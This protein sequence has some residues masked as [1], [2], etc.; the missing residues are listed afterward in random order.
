V[1]DEAT[2]ALDNET[3]KLVNK[4]IES[5]AGLKTLIVI[6]HRLSTIEH[7]DHI[8][9]LDKGQVVRSGTYQEVV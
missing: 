4:A 7:C 1:L 2:S 8:Y 6:A 5:L 3:E 9:M